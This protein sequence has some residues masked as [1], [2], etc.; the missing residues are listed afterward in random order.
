MTTKTRAGRF[1]CLDKIG[2]DE[3]FFVLRGQD[4]LAAELVELWA[5]RAKLAGTPIDKV[6]EAFAVAEEMQ[7]WPGQKAPD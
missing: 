4:K 6:N 1:D 7:N 5:I 3:P 2:P